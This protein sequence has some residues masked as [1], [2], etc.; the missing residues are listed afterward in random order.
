MPPPTLHVT[1]EHLV[2]L[3]LV[4]DFPGATPQALAERSHLVVD[5]VMR[6]LLELEVA[7][8]IVDGNS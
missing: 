8:Y 6:L 1:E 4:R 3:A 7:G 5:E 2:L